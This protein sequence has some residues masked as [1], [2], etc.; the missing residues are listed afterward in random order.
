MDAI[1]FILKN[2]NAFLIVGTGTTDSFR[3]DNFYIHRFH[4][5]FKKLVKF[6]THQEA[7]DFI[8][9]HPEIEEKFD[10]WITPTKESDWG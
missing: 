9:R 2:Y 3:W 10:A 8:D 5:D 4:A 1:V 7:Q 6:N